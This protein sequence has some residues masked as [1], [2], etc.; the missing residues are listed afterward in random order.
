MTVAMSRQTLLWISARVLISSHFVFELHDKIFHFASVRREIGRAGMPLPT[1]ELLLVI[2]LLLVGTVTLL[3][4]KYL[5]VSFICLM[6][7]QIPTTV[8]FETNDYERFDSIS[9]MGGVL[10]VALYEET[11]AKTTTTTAETTSVHD[12]ADAHTTA[13]PDR[14][15]DEEEIP[16]LL[17]R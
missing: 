5:W 3:I 17:P 10:A 7:F 16:I 13:S 9:V 12:L 2:A 8:I 6:V 11:I 14:Q 15:D 4:G 1:L